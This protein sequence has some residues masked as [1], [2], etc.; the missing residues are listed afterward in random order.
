MPKVN[1]NILSWA[2]ETAGLSTEE[3]AMKIGLY[4]TKKMNA[5]DR[6]L[7]L[8]DGTNNPTR[9]MLVKMAK[10]YRRPLLTFYMSTPPLPGDRGQDFRTLPADYFV[11]D[12]IYLYTLIR[13]V[14]ARQSMIRSVMEDDDDAEMLPFVGS[15]KMADGVSTVLDAIRKIIQID[16]SE[17]RNQ[18]TTGSAFALLRS[19]V[20]AAGVFVL[21]ISNLGSH[22]S[23]ISLE[24]FRG[25]SLADEIASFVVINDQDSRSAWSFTLIHELTHV[26]LGQSGVSGTVYEK[27]IERFCNDVASEFLLPSQELALLDVDNTTD[28]EQVE[29]R[30]SEFS[31]S[32]KLSRSMVAYK[33]FLKK[34][35]SEDMWK[36]LCITYRKSWLVREEQRRLR[37]RDSRGP[38][39]YIVRRHRVGGALIALVRRMM[40]AGSLTTL[41]AGKVLGV[42][43]KN[44]QK[45][46]GTQGLRA[47]RR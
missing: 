36:R 12:D 30:I 10:Q 39:Y 18:P 34:N 42:K 37:A 15:A 27:K 16:L 31:R 3:A 24:T 44:V 13:D 8:E 28:F 11:A 32:R 20:E 40:A 23:S 46:V 22:H 29:G 45:L 5:V 2:R 21:L 19:K 25:F 7:S 38:D 9:P 47:A 33:I 4:G 41:K 43:A 1:S 6:L 26:W 35:I 17:F 14:R